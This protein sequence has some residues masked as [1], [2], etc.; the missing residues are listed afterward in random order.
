MDCIYYS[1]IALLESMCSST[2]HIYGVC[3]DGDGDDDA[4]RSSKDHKDRS[5]FYDM[6]RSIHYNEEYNMVYSS[7]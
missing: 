3:G 5:T 6:G 7:C 4:F 2:L 1:S